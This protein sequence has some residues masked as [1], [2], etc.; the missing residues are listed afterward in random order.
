M[1]ILDTYDDFNFTII[2]LFLYIFL[3][4]FIVIIINNRKKRII[5]EPQFESNKYNSN[6]NS[7]NNTNNIQNQECIGNSSLIDNIM[8]MFTCPT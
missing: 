8:Q 5:N 2:L 1:N 3:I 7:N 6:S 4:A